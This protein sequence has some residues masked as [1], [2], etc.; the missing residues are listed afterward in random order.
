VILTKSIQVQH[1]SGKA[2]HTYTFTLFE[3]AKVCIVDKGS[4]L[5]AYRLTH[6]GKGWD[7]N[8]WGHMRHHKCWHRNEGLPAVKKMLSVND[9]EAEIAEEAMLMRIEQERY[10]KR[11]NQNEDL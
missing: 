4:Q 11:R 7:C 2:V 9:F 3:Q 5:D 1:K 10:P 8:C 6:S